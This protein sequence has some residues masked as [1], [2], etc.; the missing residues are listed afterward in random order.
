M[1]RPDKGTQGGPPASGEHDTTGFTVARRSFLGA[2]AVVVAGGAVGS[3]LSARGAPSGSARFRETFGFPDGPAAAEVVLDVPD[4]ATG[5]ATLYVTSPRETVTFALGPVTF[6]GGR[7]E[8]EATLV[9]PYRERVPGR[10][11][12]RLEVEAAGRRAITREPAVCTV[13]DILWFA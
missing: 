2:S 8:V 12:Y 6:H 7:A 10:Y 13:R 11:E 3:L 9:Y 1:A 4:G 5:H